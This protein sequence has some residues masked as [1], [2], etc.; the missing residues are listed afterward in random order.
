MPVTIQIMS[1]DANAPSTSAL[2]QPNGI[3]LVAGL[4]P[5]HIANTDIIK[6]A[7]S[8]SK[9]A[10]SVAIAKLLDKIP[11]VKFNEYVRICYK[12]RT[13]RNCILIL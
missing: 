12:N 5:T 9:C 6:L 2:Y 7:K 3:L 8:V 13:Q 1:T 4:E 10:A 11:P